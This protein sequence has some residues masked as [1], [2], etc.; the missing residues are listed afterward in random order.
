MRVLIKASYDPGVIDYLKKELS[1]YQF[2][3]YDTNDVKDNDICIAL[4][5]FVDPEKFTTKTLGQNEQMSRFDRLSVMRHYGFPVLPFH[6]LRKENAQSLLNLYDEYIHKYD[7]SYPSVL[8]SVTDKNVE[9]HIGRLTSGLA[10]KRASSDTHVIRTYLVGGHIMGTIK[11]E[12]ERIPKNGMMSCE[13]MHDHIKKSFAS[14]PIADVG[15]MKK[16]GNWFTDNYNT[17]MT[18]FEFM[19]DDEEWKLMDVN[20]NGMRLDDLIMAYSQDEI[21]KE[22]SQGLIKALEKRY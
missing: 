5:H 19:L 11:F 12:T 3:K 16:M 13:S 1:I 7:T 15:L 6:S 17:I 9:K 4:N 2:I 18:A 14:G 22:L 20:F 21:Y 8:T 10:Q